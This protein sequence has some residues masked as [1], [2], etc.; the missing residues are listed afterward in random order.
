MMLLISD[1][2]SFGDCFEGINLIIIEI[3]ISDILII[4]SR[5]LFVECNHFCQIHCLVATI[6]MTIVLFTDEFGQKMN[7]PRVRIISINSKLNFP[8]STML[9]SLTHDIFY[10]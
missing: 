9:L 5:Q 3:V 1:A 10:C 7:F 2:F 6:V 8:E 4:K